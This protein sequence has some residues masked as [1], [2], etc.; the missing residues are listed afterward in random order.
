M[1]SGLGTRAGRGPVAVPAASSTGSRS[2]LL[3]WDGAGV[4]LEVTDGGLPSCFSSW[5]YMTFFFGR[6]G[7]ATVGPNFSISRGTV[8]AAP[9][10][11]GWVPLP[12]PYPYP[13]VG[14]YP[15]GIPYQDPHTVWDTT[16]QWPVASAS[17]ARSLAQAW[18]G[19]GM[20]P[21]HPSAWFGVYT[22][23]LVVFDCTPRWV[24]EYTLET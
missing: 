6:G 8:W 1:G 3:K 14:G 18:N 24:A 2:A 19:S 4:G 20:W 15:Y 21:M 10:P 11:G 17:P 23:P 7:L 12:Y 22:R 16:A 9:K 13:L 5:G